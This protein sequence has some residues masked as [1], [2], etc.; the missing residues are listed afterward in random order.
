MPI[1]T[2]YSATLSTKSKELL[3]KHAVKKATTAPKTTSFD[4]LDVDLE[5]DDLLDE[6]IEAAPTQELIPIE[7]TGLDPRLKQMSYSSSLSLHTCPRKYELY[8]LFAL[9][10][11]IIDTE[12]DSRRSVTFTYGHVVGQGMQDI[13]AGF[14]ES[15]I[16]MN[17]FL[18]WDC[19]LLATDPFAK[20]DFFLALAAIKRFYKLRQSSDLQDYQILMYEGKPACELGCI[21]DLPDGFKYRL[22]I[23]AVLEHKVTGAIRV[24]EAKTTK[25]RAIDPAQFKNSAQAIGY[26]IVLDYLRPGLSSYDVL[27]SVYSST[28]MEYTI[29]VF[30]KTLLQ[31]AHWLRNLL[32]DKNLVEMYSYPEGSHF[33]MYG[34]SCFN[35]FHPCEYFGL[36]T[37]D[38]AKLAKPYSTAD[39]ARIKSDNAKYH[40]HVSFDELVQAQLSRDTGE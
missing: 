38:T 3:A 26:S 14:S 22:W 1:S 2:S 20:K 27:Y 11:P 19:D 40:F 37:M 34:E 8:K 16:L 28:S 24:F 35:F 9:R 18:M 32:L 30:A 33:P 6:E 10:A 21:I 5:L 13:L 15:H 4:T 17:A 39:E 25:Y 29:L 23:D 12:E 36:C 31:R 7:V